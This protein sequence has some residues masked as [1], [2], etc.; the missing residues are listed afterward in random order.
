MN[1]ST[2]TDISQPVSQSLF[3]QKLLHEQ[4]TLR[5][6]VFRDEAPSRVRN[7]HIILDWELGLQVP[8]SPP[9]HNDQFS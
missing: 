1:S 8:L 7:I 2:E 5:S 6:S 3:H 9:G 4:A